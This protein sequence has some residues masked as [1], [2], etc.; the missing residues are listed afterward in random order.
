MRW[1]IA[2]SW[3]TTTKAVS[4]SRSAVMAASTCSAYPGLDCPWVHPS[5]H[6]QVRSLTLVQSPPADARHLTPPGDGSDALPNPIAQASWPLLRPP[7]WGHHNPCRHGHALER[8]ELGQ[9]VMH[10][11][12]KTQSLIP[13]LAP[14]VFRHTES[15]SP[16]TD[17][18]PALGVSKPPNKFSKVDLPA[19]EAPT[20]AS[21]SPADTDSAKSLSTTISRG[22]HDRFYPGP[23][24][25][26]RRDQT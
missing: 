15:D 17:T 6:R 2:G 10:L 9:Q 1:A 13:P 8:R 18:S 4:R 26:A 21:H 23:Q 11:K 20:I 14:L 12:H 5:A 25:R 3:V 24:P 22:R 19:P 16:A 7:A